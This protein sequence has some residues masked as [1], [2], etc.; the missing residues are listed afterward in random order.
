TR[1]PS[2]KACDWWKNAERDF[3]TAQSMGLNSLRISVS[4]ARIEPQES[5]FDPEA[6]ERYREMISAL[7]ERNIQPVICLHHF[8]HPVWFEKEGAFLSADC[9]SDYLRF[10]KFVVSELCDLCNTWLTFNEPNIYAVESYMEG[11]HPPAVNSNLPK[12]F[13]VLGNMARCHAAAYH[14]IHAIQRE[15]LVS[16]A[17]HFIIF[18]HAKDQPFDRLAA[19]IASDYF[20][21]VFFNML[22]GQKLPPFCGLKDC[23]EPLKGTFDFIGVNIYGGVDV[24]FDLFKPHMGFVRRIKPA[25]GRTGDL[26]PQGNAMFSEIYP[27]GI[28]IV[29]EKLAHYGKPF[30]I[31]ENGVPDRDDKLRPWVIA[32]AVKTMHDLID[33]RYKIL[34]YHHWSLVDNFEW[35]IGYSMKFGLVEMDPATQERK[36]RP[37]AS[38]YSEIAK[39]NTLTPDMVKKYVPEAMG[40][41]FPDS[42]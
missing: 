27:Q 36:L 34:G 19:R 8:A 25:S 13:R 16:F 14:A 5:I 40:E 24:A 42:R 11:D 2:G 12:Y 35:A 31:L 22:E 23:K 6:I 38:F 3:D 20:N 10:V 30:F 4:W 33:R 26:D 29:V 28:K 18:T 9:V 1:E 7:I 32:C 21:N 17:N 41:I 37:S 15:S 39:A